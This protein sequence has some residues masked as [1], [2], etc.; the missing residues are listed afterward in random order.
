M[1]CLASYARDAIMNVRSAVCG[2]HSIG[3]LCSAGLCPATRVWKAAQVQES[4]TLHE[5]DRLVT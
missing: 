1:L 5:L 2:R 3:M 4:R